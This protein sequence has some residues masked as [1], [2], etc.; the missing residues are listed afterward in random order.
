[1]RNA[2]VLVITL[3]CLTV[4]NVS[5]QEHIVVDPGVLQMLQ[6]LKDSEK[7][8]NNLKF[9]LSNPLGI[10]IINE[11]GEA[12][13]PDISSDGA[14]VLNTENQTPSITISGEDHGTMITFPSADGGVIEIIFWMN[15][16]PVVL[17]FQRNTQNSRYIVFSATINTKDYR[18]SSSRR[19]LPHLLIKSNINDTAAE[20]FAIHASLGVPPLPDR[21]SSLN[22]RQPQQFNSQRQQQYNRDRLPVD[23]M[24]NGNLDARRLAGFLLRN[25]PQ[26]G[27]FAYELASLYVEEALNEG[28]NHDIAFAQMCL[29][30]G[31][32]KFGRIVQRSWNNFC[33][34]GAI[35]EG[36]GSIFPSARIGVRAHIQ[37]LKAYASTEP[38]NGGVRA[39]DDRFY[40]V[41]R[42]SSPTIYGLTGR[43]AEDTQYADKIYSVLRRL[44]E[45]S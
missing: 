34:L 21:S 43:W 1:M 40:Y 19:E 2:A 30:T 13:E 12:P 27:T 36:Q 11:K 8:I 3:I 29:E 18:L 10:F 45:F 31:F 15:G 22:Q 33:G 17:K 39:E 4:V 20:I 37:H 6:S 5:G 28:V 41:A 38:L 16:K 25:N 32:L 26:A 14:L 44:Y 42:G 23:I 24:G 9:Y 35:G 7:P